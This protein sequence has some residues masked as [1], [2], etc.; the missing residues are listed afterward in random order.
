MCGI[1]GY[2]VLDGK[3]VR[4]TA[5]QAIARTLLRDLEHRGRDATGYAYVSIKDKSA[6][7]AKA[8]VPASDFIS[9]E[10]HLLSNVDIKAMP[11]TMILHTRFATQGLASDNRNNHTVY[12][13]KS[14]LCMVHNGWLINDKELV[15]EHDLKKDAEVDS[16]T[17]LR[18]IEKEYYNGSKGDITKSI[19]E[20][21]KSVVGNIA[22]AMV[23]GGAPGTLWLWRQEGDLRLARTDF[24][25]VFASELRA[26][27]QGLY[28]ST[29][30]IDVSQVTIIEVPPGTLLELKANG[31][32][33]KLDIEAYDFS[34]FSGT[35]EGVYVTRGNGR[36]YHLRRMRGGTTYYMGVDGGFQ[37]G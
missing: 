1:A 32:V 8:P 31:E 25:F 29:R 17:Y 18:L 4:P 23:K 21:T 24:G 22:C 20:A 28:H 14:E 2:I 36:K 19:V 11:R 15:K 3:R 27:W 26:L 37:Q 7:V 34:E 13:K 10:G 6:Y 35:K 30:A 16:E 9:I 33:T 5:L 12:S